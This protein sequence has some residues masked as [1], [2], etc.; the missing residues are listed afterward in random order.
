[1]WLLIDFK[2]PVAPQARRLHALRTKTMAAS[3]STRCLCDGRRMAFPCFDQPDLKAKFRL[4]VTT[5]V[6][7]SVISNTAGTVM[8]IYTGGNGIR[9]TEFAETKP[10]STYLFAFAAGPFQK[11][12]DTPGCQ[13][14]MFG[15]QNCRKPRP[16]QR[17]SNRSRP[18]ASRILPTILPSHFPPQVRT[19]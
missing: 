12:H 7:W 2:A 16:R 18:T 5:A 14:F 3:T 15:N 13:D 11:V 19:W 1:M 4:T 10:I 6:D 8:E 17:L 9:R